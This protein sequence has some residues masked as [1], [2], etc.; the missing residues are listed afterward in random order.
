LQ[1]SM[2]SYEQFLRESLEGERRELDKLYDEF[3]HANS[4]R[5][6]LIKVQIDRTIQNLQLISYDLEK[7]QTA[8][9][10]LRETSKERDELSE[11]L[12]D[13]DEKALA[14]EA[15][16]PS[17]PSAKGP[18]PAPSS[19]PQPRPAPA[20]AGR[21]AIGKPLATAQA[22]TPE[23]QTMHGAQASAVSQVQTAE[24]QSGTVPARPKI[25]QPIGTQA[26]KPA[27]S[28]QL[29]NKPTIGTP[30]AR[31]AVGTPIPRPTIG[32]PIGKPAAPKQEEEE[33]Q[34]TTAAEGEQSEKKPES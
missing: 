18:T 28:N 6:Q 9:S 24:Q 4:I 1:K 12:G 7:Y 33:G 26:G 3:A 10:Y 17:A 23:Q 19:T 11:H 8:L 25:G 22:S 30:V 32:T 14:Q 29:A 16:T 34:Q 27:T 15:K 2:T 20:V 31:P 13:V 21:P 5:K